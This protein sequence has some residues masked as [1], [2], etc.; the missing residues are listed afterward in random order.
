MK[1]AVAAALLALVV[2]TACIPNPGPRVAAWLAAR[3]S[4]AEPNFVHTVIPADAL[5]AWPK[6]QGNPDCRVI[7]E[8]VAPGQPRYTAPYTAVSFLASVNPNLWMLLCHPPNR[9]LG[10]SAYAAPTI[11]ITRAP[12]LPSQTPVFECVIDTPPRVGLPRGT[13]EYVGASRFQSTNRTVW[14]RG[15]VQVV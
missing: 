12:N 15:Y 2:A 11:K 13:C 4:K 7:A 10:P 5:T 14:D 9:G 6:T 8:P 3:P 1:R